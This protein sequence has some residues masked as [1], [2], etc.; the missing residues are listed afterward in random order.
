MN[1]FST[2][3]EEDGIQMI[4]VVLPLQQYIDY[5]NYVKGSEQPTTRR[6][7]RILRGLAGICELFQ[8]SQAQAFKIAHAEWFQPAVVKMGRMMVF[9]ADLAWELAHNQNI[10]P[11]A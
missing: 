10:K 4:R 2:I 3:T 1:E 5:L 11:A 7:R 6:E 8:C 9:D